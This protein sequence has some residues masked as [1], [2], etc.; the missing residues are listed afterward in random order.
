[1]HILTPVNLP[2]A[3]GVGVDEANA[4]VHS[5]NHSPGFH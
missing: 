4:L 2:V 5:T 3:R 1:M